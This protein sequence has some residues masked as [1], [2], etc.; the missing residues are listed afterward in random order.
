[1]YVLLSGGIK[2]YAS[3]YNIRIHIVIPDLSS[4]FLIR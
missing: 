2:T 4:L 3:K 1:M